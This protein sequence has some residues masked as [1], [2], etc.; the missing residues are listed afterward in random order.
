VVKTIS[1]KQYMLKIGIILGDGSSVTNSRA[2]SDLKYFLFGERLYFDI[3][4]RLKQDK[5]G[6][7]IHLIKETRLSGMFSAISDENYDLLISFE[8]ASKEMSGDG[9]S[10]RYM[11]GNEKARNIAEVFQQ[12]FVAG[13]ELKNNGAKAVSEVLTAGQFM[14]TLKTPC[15]VVEPFPSSISGSEMQTFIRNYD[16]IVNAYVFSIVKIRDRFFGDR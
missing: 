12:F 15:I 14:R 5:K 8:C 2:N 13:S 16:K 1:E 9:V 11:A 7:D 3:L 10:V 6:F 4:K